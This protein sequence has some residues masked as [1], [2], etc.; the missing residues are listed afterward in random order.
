MN[1]SPI[2]DR[3]RRRAEFCRQCP[4]CRRARVRQRG[5]AFWFVKKVEGGVCPKCRAYEKVYGRK[6]H[7]PIPPDKAD[8]TPQQT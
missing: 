3:D 2:T 4:I 5:L 8:S 1:D 7:E 6:A